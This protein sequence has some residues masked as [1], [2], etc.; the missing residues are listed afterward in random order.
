[1]TNLEKFKEWIANAAI[2]QIAEYLLQEYDGVLYTSD[3]ESFCDSK[4]DI[5][6]KH[7]I[8]WL[9]KQSDSEYWKKW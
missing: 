3:C 9:K 1:M 5:A 2:E 6:L 7:E 8:E 4:K